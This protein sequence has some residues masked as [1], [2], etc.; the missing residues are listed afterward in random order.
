MSQQ[1]KLEILAELKKRRSELDQT[2]KYLNLNELDEKERITYAEGFGERLALHVKILEIER[3]LGIVRGSAKARDRARENRRM[4]E[5]FEAREKERI[6]NLPPI[7]QEQLERVQETMR[8]YLEYRE[9]EKRLKR[10]AY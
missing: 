6:R 1:E 8:A 10:T 4:R 7:D 9:R 2:W 5:E 3:H